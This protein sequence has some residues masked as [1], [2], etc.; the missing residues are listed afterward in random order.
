MINGIT[1]LTALERLEPCAGKL[2]CTVLRGAN[3]SNVVGLLDFAL[4]GT[5]Y[6]IVVSG[7]RFEIDLLMYNTK[8]HLYVVVELKRGDFSPKDTGQ[9][10]FY[11]SAVDEQLKLPEDGPT[12]GLL[13]CEKKDKVIAEYS[14]R[15]VSSPMGIAEYELSKSLTEKLNN[16]LPTTEEIETEL[17]A[18]TESTKILG[19]DDVSE[20]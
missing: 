9:L 4:Y 13:L 2:A 5:R 8:L 20:D 16:V 3:N 10:N 17:S 14:L 12:I 1:G 18:Y 7:K 19:D 11:L 6:P 15:R